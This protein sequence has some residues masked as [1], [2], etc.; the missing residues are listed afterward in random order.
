MS[1]FRFRGVNV[2][3]VNVQV[4][5]CLPHISPSPPPC[6]SFPPQLHVFHFSM[7][8][9]V[10]VYSS[11]TQKRVQ[12]CMKI[13]SLDPSFNLLH[14]SI[15]CVHVLHVLIVILMPHLSIFFCRILKEAAHRNDIMIKCD[16]VI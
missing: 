7:P 4:G 13:D 3:W 1:S 11:N 5:K 2:W 9:T 15:T 10:F 14:Q 16:Q 8:P 6:Q 12:N